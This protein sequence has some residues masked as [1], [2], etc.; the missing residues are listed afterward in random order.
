ML[1]GGVLRGKNFP[2][3]GVLVMRKER[4]YY[5]V[6]YACFGVGQ[7]FLCKQLTCICSHSERRRWIEHLYLFITEGPL[8]RQNLV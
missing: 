6:D 2:K 1:C 3:L 8:D 7:Y 5:H 4:M